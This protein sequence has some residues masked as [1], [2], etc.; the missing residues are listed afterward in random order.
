MS[1][2]LGQLV[3]VHLAVLGK[4]KSIYHRFHYILC[5]PHDTGRC[6]VQR[7]HATHAFSS[8]SGG[9]RPKSSPVL[10]IVTHI[11]KE[12]TVVVCVCVPTYTHHVHPS[13][14]TIRIPSMFVNDLNTQ[15]RRESKP[16]RKESNRIKNR[17]G[18]R[19]HHARQINIS[20]IPAGSGRNHKQKKTKQ[21]REG[22]KKQGKRGEYQA[23]QM[24]IMK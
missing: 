8:P 1:N 21:K 3:R 17:R 12:Y 23:Q 4:G 13:G 14:R 20:R 10:K 7:D 22:K 19:S 11:T 9:S 15:G 18:I 5:I 2:P 16:S 24:C 6:Q